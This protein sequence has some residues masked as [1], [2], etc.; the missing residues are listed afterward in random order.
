MTSAMSSTW[1]PRA[2]M[3]VATSTRTSP[4]LKSARLRSRALCD[5]F[6]CSSTAGIPAAQQL[7]G[8]LL[9]AVLGAHEQQRAIEAGRQ[10]TDDSGLVAGRNGEDVM[11]H[12][13]DRG[14][15]RVD[16]V[17]DG[18]DEV[19]ANQAIDRLVERCREQQALT[20]GRGCIE[21]ALD[22]GEEAEVG[23]VVGLVEHGHF[24]RV[25][26][27]VPLADEVFEA[28]R[29]GNDDVDAL[30]KCGHLRALA[31]AAVDGA[32]PQRHCRG[33]GPARS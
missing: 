2:A 23:H 3:S 30:A 33:E 21:D 9:G 7:L 14:H 4:L 6:P 26:A 10:R 32:D 31:D 16:R 15:F 13:V 22:A 27:A 28:A 18:V 12:R 8:E 24:D 17:H 1:M 20:A 25:E 29:A 11:C 19:L 5:R